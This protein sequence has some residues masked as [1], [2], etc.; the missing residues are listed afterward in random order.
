MDSAIRAVAERTSA[1]K[2][3]ITL[4]ADLAAEIR[5]TAG[6]GGVSGFLAD[7]ARYYIRRRKLM[8]SLDIGF[9]AWG[10]G[11]PTESGRPASTLQ[12]LREA[13]R[14][15]AERLRRL[16]KGEDA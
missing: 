5:D 11:G 2:L 1:E 12:R 15:R 7:A 13:G 10:P 8:H 3:S 9:G 6:P 4:P 14:D 16:M